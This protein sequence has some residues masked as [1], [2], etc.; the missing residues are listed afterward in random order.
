MYNECKLFTGPLT[1]IIVNL[2][3]AEGL[4]TT[5]KLVVALCLVLT[6]DSKERHNYSIPGYVYDPE[7]PLNILR[8]PAL[9]AYL[10]YGADI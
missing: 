9:G 10:D 3:T 6:D 8:V 4:I 7:I 5:T 1:L 2:A